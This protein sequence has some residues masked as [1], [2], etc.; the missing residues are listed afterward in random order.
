MR[1]KIF[2]VFAMAVS[3]VLASCGGGG[4]GGGGGSAG[5]S[6]DNILIT[7]GNRRKWTFVIY[8]AADNDLEGEAMRNINQLEA[9]SSMNSNKIS[10]LVLIDRAPGYDSTDGDWTDTRLYEIQHD[11]AGVN[12]A[13]VSKRLACP[14]LEITEDG[15][16]ELDMSDYRVLGSVL[17]FAR[18]SYQA[19]N[20]ALIVWGHGTGWRSAGS[21]RAF[22]VDDTTGYSSSMPVSQMRVALSGGGLSFVGFDTCFS[23]ILEVCYELKNCAST[24]IGT[25]GL[26]PGSGWNYEQLFTAFA[27]GDMSLASFEDCLLSSYQAQYA[28]ASGTA[29]SVID[30]SKIQAVFSAFESLSETLSG[31]IINASIRNAALSFF[32]NSSA[33]YGSTSFPSDWFIS[34]YGFAERTAASAGIFSTDA[35]V[36]AEIQAKADV[37]K[38][39][40]S[41]AVTKSWSADGIA[42]PLGVHVVPLTGFS[43]PASRHSD[44]YMKGTS[45]LYKPQFVTDSVWYVPSQPPAQSLLDKIF[46]VDFN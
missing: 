43:T 14:A 33:G 42:K 8:M 34:L 3:L 31:C 2:Y 23:A 7:D 38:D 37:L 21:S 22:A 26:A 40:V 6:K 27:A 5:L 24:V 17:S 19:E 15:S 44:A 11:P 25:H 16:K 1:N 18:S 28:S 30:S 9:V 13:V 45:V 46:Y 12:T 36:Q 35:A 41:A 10:V 39:A 20:Y 29:V 32:I 4:G